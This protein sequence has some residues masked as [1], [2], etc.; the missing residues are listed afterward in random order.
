M[1]LI[2]SVMTSTQSIYWKTVIFLSLI[3]DGKLVLLIKSFET[4]DS[5]FEED[6]IHHRSV[7]L[8]VC[9]E[10]GNVLDQDLDI[11]F[12]GLQVL[13]LLDSQA[14][15]DFLHYENEMYLPFY[16]LVLQPV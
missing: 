11:L 7:L 9:P 5:F 1:A 10:V 15:V 6:P 16:Q 2:F 4:F 13:G 14:S 3:V 8:V 12:E